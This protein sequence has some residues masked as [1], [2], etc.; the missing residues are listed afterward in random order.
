MEFGIAFANTGPFV[1]A[2]AA[3][4]FAR[5]AEDAGIE[6]LW[7]VEHVVVPAGYE[8]QYP[9]DP[10]GKM[11]GG[12]DFD[13]PDPLI[14]LTWVAAATS[15]IRLATGILIL[16]QR[17][18]VVLAKE[19]ATLDQ[20]SGGRVELGIGV[21]WLEEEFEAIGVPFD[22]RGRRTDDHVGAM[23]A[24]WSQDR[25]TFDGEFTS[26]RDCISRPRP[27]DGAI[28]IHIGGHTDIAARRAGRLGD[29]FFPGRGEAPELARLI[30]VVRS[31]AAEHG[32][33][34]DAI[35]VSAGAAAFGRGALDAVKE[36]ADLGVSRIMLP[37]F[38]FWND[39][40]DSLNRY[41]DEVI[42]KVR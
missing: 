38:P 42:G 3:T 36:M 26:F 2:D 25:A 6:S 13:I 18:P 10:S 7:T 29:G 39:T 33:D 37:S 34:P 8:S 12:E 27:V 17:N 40:R 41:A 31:T 30:E 32:R 11:P 4:E 23:R 35:E 19:L 15:T 1:H 28:P 5:A 22:E 20:L 9:Y 24:L 16:P 21:G 14:W